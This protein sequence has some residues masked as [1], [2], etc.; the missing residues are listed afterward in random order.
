MAGKGLSVQ[1]AVV[2]T[3]GRKKEEG[4][5]R[6]LLKTPDLLN[7]VEGRLTVRRLQAVDHARRTTK[8]GR[9]SA[10]TSREKHNLKRA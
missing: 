4:P 8:S 6:S 1:P 7:V 9:C 2:K 5:K 10:S 3:E